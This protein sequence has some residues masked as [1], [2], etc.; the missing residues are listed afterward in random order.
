[1]ARENHNHPQNP[2]E[3]IDTT[4]GAIQDYAALHKLDRVEAALTLILNELRCLHWH[5]D[6]DLA[7]RQ[8]QAKEKADG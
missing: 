6:I 8:A 1:M 4:S 5:F 3:L 2:I 7:E